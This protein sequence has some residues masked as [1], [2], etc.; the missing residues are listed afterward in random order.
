MQTC[1]PVTRP[2]AEA[3]TAILLFSGATTAAERT[4]EAIYREHCQSCHGEAGQGTEAVPERLVGERSVSQLA[5]YVS[6]TMPEGDPEAVTG[7]D[8]E[9]VAAYIHA[10]FYSPIAQERRRPAREELS[11]LTVRQHR[12]VLADLVGSFGPQSWT[13]T[14]ER[15]LQGQYYQGRNHD[16]KQ[17]VFERVDPT[18]DFD[19]GLE[20]PDPEQFEPGRFAIRWVGSV[21]PV[22]TG[23][24]EFIIRTAH[25]ATLTV[26]AGWEDPPLID[27]YVTSGDDTEYRGRI[28]LLGGRAYPLRIEFSK[29]NQGV[30]NE[31]RE[32]PTHASIELAWKPPHGVEQIV[33]EHCLLPRQSQPVFVAAT[34]FPPDDR[35]IGY[36]RGTSVSRE[37][38]DAARAVAIETG[39]HV[40]DSVDR[41]A[42]TKRDDP[43]R[44]EKL[45]AF[46]ATFAERA[47]RRPLTDELRQRVVERP[48]ADAPDLDAGLTRSLFL[49]LTS[50]RFLFRSLPDEALRGDPYDVA[51]RLSFG[52][53]D[54]IPDEPL[55]QAAA[56]GQLAAEAE[57]TGQI[58]RMLRDRRCRAKLHDFF[59]SWLR[60]DQPPELVKD[61]SLFPHFTP[62]VAASLRASL[63]RTIDT[64][65]ADLASGRPTDYR[66]L[67]ADDEVFLDHVLGEFYGVEV[68]RTRGFRRVRLD[69]GR[70]AGVLTHPYILS[71]LAYTDDTSPIHRGVFLARAVL[72]NVLEPPPEA[73]APLAPDLHPDLTTR[74]RVMLQTEDVSCQSCHAMINPLG[75]ALEEF[76]AV[77]R[78]RTSER[79]GELS[80]PIDA[81]GLYLPRQ[82]DRVRFTGSR[83]LAAYLATSR[84]SQEAFVEDLFHAVAKQP[85]RAWGDETQESLRAAF[86][87]NGFDIRRLLVD[88]MQVVSR[89]AAERSDLAATVR[90]APP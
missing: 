80:K 17:L 28:F 45:R 9:A 27:A 48:F 34:P 11:R 4:G 25:S 53:W 30:D 12:E 1:G 38:F 8:A 5:G 32:M 73:V 70:R 65:L 64:L 14:D 23:E 77:G 81:S 78:Y 19:F 54:S 2:L 85:L 63:H 69:E 33:P 82:G 29:A 90:G 49:T 75:F 35:G 44:G 56:A 40:L 79:A 22:E 18:V 71:L 68:P 31:D 26:N 24:Y 59:V 50:P 60:V 6:D 46:A 74:E 72:G 52:L 13:A 3:L 84:D 37:W 15:G 87:A 21:V 58:E 39:G 61:P 86:E 10:S 88:I 42:G 7:D 47:F 20:G 67:F 55:R 36:E 41:L 62:A 51:A 89:P 57:I 66:R 76:D 16:R 83:E 43:A